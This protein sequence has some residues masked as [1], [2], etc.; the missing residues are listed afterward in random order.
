[1][2][3]LDIGCGLES[4]YYKEEGAVVVHADKQSS[5][6][7][8]QA[9]INKKLPFKD[10]EFDVVH[11]SHILEH[12]EDIF[13]SMD[14]IWRV[15]KVGG[16]LKI[17]VPFWASAAAFTHPEHKHYFGF[18]TFDYWKPISV[19]GIEKKRF[20]VLKRRIRIFHHDHH[21]ILEK[22][23]YPMQIL[24]DFFPKVYERFFFGILPADEL[25]FELQKV[26]I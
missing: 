12:V 1:M 25:H 4:T 2:K 13:F 7:T 8:V 14:E 16:I 18:W 9:D 26:N 3:I 17:Y 15:L 11:C 6:G 5:L 23:F 24:I 22:I 20:N 19:D 10:E 21:R